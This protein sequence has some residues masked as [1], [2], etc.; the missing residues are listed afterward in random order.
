M[1][2]SRHLRAAALLTALVVPATLV[3]PV[4]SAPAAQPRPVSPVVQQ[5]PVRGV[6]PVALPDLDS[7]TT[8]GAGGSQAQQAPDEHLEHQASGRLAVLTSQRPVRP[9]RLVGLTWAA[10]EVPPTGVAV[11]TRV[12]GA[13]SGWEPLEVVDDAPD[14]DTDEGRRSRRGVEPLLVPGADG[15]QLRVDTHDGST[16]ADLRLELVDPGSS[17]ADGNVAAVPPATAAAAASTPSIVTRAQWGADESLR[18]AP[19]YMATVKVGFVHHSA[20]SNSYWQSTGWTS[21]DAAKDI[22][23][24]YAY[25]TKGL[26]YA[27]IAYSFLVDLAGRIYEGRAGGV[28]RAVQSAATGGF[29]TDT[30]AVAALGNLDIASPSSALVDGISR[31]MAWKLDLFHRDPY[32]STVLTSAGGGTSRHAAGTRVTV[33]TVSGH[34]DVGYTACPGRYLYPTLATIKAKAKAYQGAA[35]HNPVQSAATGLLGAASVQ[36]GAT[37]PGAQSWRLTVRSLCLGNTAVR[38]LSGS[39]TQ[40]GA[41]SVSWD[42]KTS[43][44]AVAP[45]GRY[46]LLLESSSTTTTGTAR[47]VQLTY[48]VRDPAVAALTCPNVGR[49]FGADRFATSVAIGKVAAPSSTSAVLVSGEDAHLVDGL[50]AAPLARAKGAPLLLTTATTLPASVLADLRARGVTR[51]WVVGGAG[52]VG[53]GVESAVRGLGATVTRLEGADRYATAAAVARE[54]GTSGRALVASGETAHLV[55]ALAAG[56]AA[57]GARRPILLVRRDAV[58]TETAQALAQLQVAGVTLV[59]GTGAVSDAV[60]A[61]L[62]GVYRAAGPDRYAT[63][64]AVATAFRGLVDPAHVVLSSGV[65][66]NIVD[67]LPGGALGRITLLTSP[68]LLSAPSRTW[69]AGEPVARA[70]VLGGP[71]AVSD[72]ALID[73]AQVVG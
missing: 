8:A 57:A 33:N 59:G 16:P 46:G 64:A 7:A 23:A 34:R 73:L 55:D 18:E 70:T 3:L 28:D 30:F 35:I 25:D 67:A 42:G 36:V 4:A 12:D 51:V 69:V 10:D 56:G 60:A 48:D 1:D 5:L 27:D 17:A 61:R 58:P 68:G 62:P 15:V 11:R 45:V 52:A 44:G 47:S 22:R 26:G 71:S 31:V 9:F 21:A 40:A 54:V 65:G 13:W 53:A 63:A 43:T 39:T 37:V 14:A 32:G 19:R 2:L 38:V 6:D 29:N 50:I 20:S 24:I 49:L 41:L 72:T 66:T